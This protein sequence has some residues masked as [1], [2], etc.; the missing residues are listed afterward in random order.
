MLDCWEVGHNEAHF[1]RDVAGVIFADD[2]LLKILCLEIELVLLTLFEEL[3]WQFCHILVHIHL[4]REVV[5]KLVQE[6]LDWRN[7]YNN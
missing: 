3:E 1:E 6:D 5:L 4:Q 2:I 7:L